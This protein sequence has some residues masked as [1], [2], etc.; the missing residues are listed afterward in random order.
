MNE[1][2]Q[3]QTKECSGCQERKLLDDFSKRKDTKDGRHY[4]CKKCA[5]VHRNARRKRNPEA[6]KNE[7][8]KRDFGITLSQYKVMLSNQHGVCAIC[9]Q[10]ETATYRGRLR[11]LSVDH[12]HA[13]GKI[14]GLLCNDCNV[15]LG[16]FKDDSTRMRL[17]ADYIDSKS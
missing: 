8:L 15:G 7:C 17:A 16:W 1:E 9:S 12:C 3:L 4:I 2:L 10:P 14:R 5:N 11:H 13:T 6:T